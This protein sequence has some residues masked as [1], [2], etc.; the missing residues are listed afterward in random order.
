[1]N[2]DEALKMVIEN[3]ELQEFN[4][5][6]ATLISYCKEA[7]EQNDNLLTIAYMSGVAEGKSKA[8]EQ[9]AKDHIE[10]K[11]HMVK[12]TAYMGTS[13]DGQPNKFR[14]NEFC[15]ATPLYTHPH[16]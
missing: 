11:L 10:D 6:N 5:V 8:L 7:L 3:L 1:M 15:G 16:Q 4:T 12:P 9:P 2:K 14:L 13:Q